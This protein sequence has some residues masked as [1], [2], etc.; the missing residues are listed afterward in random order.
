MRTLLLFLLLA[1]F[2]SCTEEKPGYYAGENYVQFYNSAASVR[3]DVKTN[4]SKYPSTLS[5]S[6]TRDTAYF[7]VQV[8]GQPSDKPR[9]VRFEQYYDETD[10]YP[11]AEPGV[12]YVPFDDASLQEMMVVPGDT[13]YAEIPVVVLYDV[14]LPSGGTTQYRILNFRIVDSEDLI[15][16]Q[17]FLSKGRLQIQQR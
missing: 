2:V 17:K 11:Q 9:K 1:A 5:A 13:A 16:G 4:P 14:T 15:L 7:K 6:I 3:Y 10:T 12:N 8:I